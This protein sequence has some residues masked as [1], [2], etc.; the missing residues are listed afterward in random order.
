MG[1]FGTRYIPTCLD[2]IS[3]QCIKLTFSFHLFNW[4][5]LILY[6][7]S[8]TLIC[9]LLDTIPMV[10]LP[11]NCLNPNWQFRLL[12]FKYNKTRPIAHAHLRWVSSGVP[13]KRITQGKYKSLHMFGFA[14]NV[15]CELPF[16]LYR[17]II[18][19]EECH[20]S[21]IP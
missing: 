12:L 18:K 13:A 9:A 21:L 2:A 16:L 10:G 6:E 15:Y 7:I 19:Y 17:F 8:N 20:H 11:M 3:F 5:R 1:Y 4:F 14:L